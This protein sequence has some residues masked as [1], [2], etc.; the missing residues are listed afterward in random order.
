MR[1][2]KGQLHL[3]WAGTGRR[4]T[5][6]FFHRRS[7]TVGIPPEEL[8]LDPAALRAVRLLGGWWL[9]CVEL[10]GRRLATLSVVPGERA[11]SVRLWIARSDRR[12]A[13]ALVWALTSLLHD[14]SS[15]PEGDA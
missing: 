6:D 13:G 12:T 15:G 10:T 9:P 11:G 14:A 8:V 4:V 1:V 5:A 7:E 2:E 3:E